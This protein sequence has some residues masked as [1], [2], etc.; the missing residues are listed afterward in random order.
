[1][2][3]E[4]SA[5]DER[6]GDLGLRPQAWGVHSTGAFLARRGL[7]AFPHRC[8]WRGTPDSAHRRQVGGRPAYAV[9]ALSRGGRMTRNR[10]RALDCR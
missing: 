7:E 1:M 5:I 6:R 3:V 4:Y 9:S 10:P 2:P 8:R